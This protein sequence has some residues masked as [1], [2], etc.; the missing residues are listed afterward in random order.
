MTNEQ[1][2]N[3]SFDKIYAALLGKIERKGHAETDLLEI[4]QWLM[5]YEPQQVHALKARGKTFADFMDGAPQ[6][7][8]SRALITGS[9]CGEKVQEITDPFRR[10]MRCLDK[11][12]DELAHGK[13]K[14]KIFRKP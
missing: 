3:M 7:N 10:D 5:G 6:W 14:E 13:S 9:I 11:L 4:I 1:I 12:V 8:P 2:R